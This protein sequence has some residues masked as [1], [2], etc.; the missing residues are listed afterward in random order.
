M[1]L[2][3]T[4]EL[5]SQSNKIGMI[6]VLFFIIAGALA[7]IIYTAVTNKQNYKRQELLDSEKAAGIKY[8]FYDLEYGF[9][10]ATA[11]IFILATVLLGFYT[12][13]NTVG[14]IAFWAV[15]GL[16][17]LGVGGNA[18]IGALALIDFDKLKKDAG[19]EKEAKGVE[20]ADKIYYSRLAYTSFAV[21]GF[22]LLLWAVL[23]V[24]KVT[25]KK[26][27]PTPIPDI[28][29]YTPA[30]TNTDTYSPVSATGVASAP[31][32]TTIY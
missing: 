2:T 14:N 32:T 7:G 30:N 8:N 28:P 10:A 25:E 5:T 1:G 9:F 12:F 29:N 27:G 21:L 31:Y 16:M 6:I 18:V 4:N 23:I 20:K 24:L 19:G 13:R 15:I 3:N 22:T 17:T 11:Y 26:V